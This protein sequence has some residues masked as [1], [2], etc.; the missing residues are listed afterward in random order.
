[1]KVFIDANILVSV[2]NKEYP[3]FSYSSR[4]LSLADSKKFKLFTSPVCLAIAFYFSEKKSGRKMAKQK[5]QTIIS[6][7]H[8]AEADRKAV[9]LAAQHKAVEDFED[10][11][12]YY[13]ALNAGC[14][15]IVTENTCDF[16]FSEI[17][18]LQAYQFL[19][20]HVIKPS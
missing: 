18:V 6:R 17:E 4:L 16:Y 20:Q 1:M 11:L 19:E 15:C 7:I 10:G 12:E 3:L 13:A 5:I 8:I 14:Q 2:L 9:M